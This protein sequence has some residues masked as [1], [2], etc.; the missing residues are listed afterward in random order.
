MGMYFY[1]H[2]LFCGLNEMI[3]KMDTFLRS[4]HAEKGSMVFNENIFN[5]INYHLEIYE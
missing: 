4:G 3:R 5:L 2:A 1:I